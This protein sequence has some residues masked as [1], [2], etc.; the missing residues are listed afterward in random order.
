LAERTLTLGS[1]LHGPDI[2]YECDPEQVTAV[3]TIYFSSKNVVKDLYSS[4]MGVKY[5]NA[6]DFLKCNTP[7]KSLAFII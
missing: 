1:R 3:L 4:E 6:C 2:F 5:D 7:S